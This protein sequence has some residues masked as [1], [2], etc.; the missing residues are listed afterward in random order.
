MCYYVITIPFYFNI[1]IVTRNTTDIRYLIIQRGMELNNMYV[2]P[3]Y[4]IYIYFIYPQ[5]L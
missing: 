2:Y 4:K 3:F 1:L 5:I